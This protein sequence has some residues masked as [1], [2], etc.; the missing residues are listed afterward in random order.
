MSQ[1]E[2]FYISNGYLLPNFHKHYWLGATAVQWPKFNWT[3]IVVP[4]MDKGY[5]HWGTLMPMGVREPYQ[6]DPPETCAVANATQVYGNP[7][8]WG[9]SDNKCSNQYYPMCR[10]N[11]E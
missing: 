7:I 1:V 10:I 8:A 6:V 3:D 2:N 9:W 4:P 11:S 5:K